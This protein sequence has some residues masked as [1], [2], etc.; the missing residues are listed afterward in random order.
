MPQ[1]IKRKRWLISI[2]GTLV[3]AA[4]SLGA[5]WVG[6]TYDREAGGYLGLADDASTAPLKLQYL[7]QYREAVHRLVTG[8]D[9]RLVFGTPQTKVAHQ[10]VVL[11]SLLERVGEVAALDVSS[12]EYQVAMDQITGQEFTGAIEVTN[13]LLKGAYLRQGG[14]L[15]YLWAIG[16]FAGL[17]GA[18]L[19]ALWLTWLGQY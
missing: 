17:A 14:L 2:I 12:F 18:F 5:Y 3:V 6:Y 7:E 19:V 8:K 4:L 1:S 11:D 13:G 10:F 16:L 15:G 9:A